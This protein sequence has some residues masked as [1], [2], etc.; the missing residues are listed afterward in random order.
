[1]R[2]F[3]PI[4]LCTVAYKCHSKL[5]ENRLKQVLPHFIDHAQSAFVAG[6]TIYDNIILAQEFFRRYSRDT[7]V[8]KCALSFDLH[9]AFDFI[10]WDFLVAALEKMQFPPRFVQWIKWCICSPM[11]Y[12][13]LNDTL[14]DYCKGAKG[15]TKGTLFP[16]TF[17][18]RQ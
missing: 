15:L 5:M 3:F 4:S 6:R 10:H 18:L 1:M 9:K 2:E 12:V 11:Y 14:N 13:K 17:S 7:G 8:A 16:F